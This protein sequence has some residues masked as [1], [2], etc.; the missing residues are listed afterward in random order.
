MAR[1]ADGCVV[2]QKNTIDCY[3]FYAESYSRERSVNN[4]AISVTVQ[5]LRTIFTIVMALSLGEAFKQV[6]ADRAD[7]GAECEKN[8]IRLESLVSLLAM[9]VLIIP[10]HHGMFRYFAD[11]YPASKMPAI[12]PAYLI[13]DSMGFTT[14]AGLFFIMSRSLLPQQWKHFYGA[15]LAILLTDT[16]WGTVVYFWHRPTLAPWLLLNCVSLLA[17]GGL[18]TL[19]SYV[20]KQWNVP[21]M[22][23]A[24]AGCL[25]MLIRTIVDYATN[26]EFYFPEA[27][28]VGTTSVPMVA[29]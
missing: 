23:I 5:S 6:V 25:L 16:L 21:P 24:I 18:V 14:E 29:P 3:S 1:I 22:A 19:G 28:G 12:Y 26:W 13:W 17:F 27:I 4:E 20:V 15:V 2:G 8:L 7:K 10:F 11:V 9:L